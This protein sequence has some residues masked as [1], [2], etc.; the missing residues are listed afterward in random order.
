MKKIVFVLL[1]LFC[2][3]VMAD[4]YDP[5]FKA[6]G[7]WLKKYAQ[8]NGPVTTVNYQE[9]HKKKSDIDLLSTGI[10]KMEKPKFEA[11]SEK[12]RLA[13]LINS[14]NIL[15]VKWIL[16]HYP[17][18]SIKDTGS[19]FQSPWKKKFFKLFGEEESLDGI[20]HERIRKKFNEPRIHFALVCASKGC[21]ALKGVPYLASELDK[22]LDESLV[23]FL[24]DSSRN[25]YDAKENTLFLSKIFK[26]YGDDFKMGSETV[27]KFVAP[28][29]GKTPAEIE[30]I[31]NSKLEFLDYDW[32]LNETSYQ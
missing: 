21:P 10:E 6:W 15:T 12:E 17:V 31:K 11:L 14:Y 26:W 2:A 32:A 28:R 30:Q 16:A 27:Q 23:G 3:A 29:M 22:Q 13:F 9:A 20:E 7:E 1:S 8:V 19:L 24:Q 5:S 25:R 18:K 4:D